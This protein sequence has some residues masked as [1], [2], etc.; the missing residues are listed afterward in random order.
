[1]VEL[2]VECTDV[3]RGVRLGTPEATQLDTH[4]AVTPD[5]QRY[6]SRYSVRDTVAPFWISA[7]VTLADRLQIV[8]DLYDGAWKFQEC[9][10]CAV[11]SHTRGVWSGWWHLRGR[12]S[13]TQDSS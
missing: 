9:P 2:H 10:G 8:D 7:D 13:Y 3:Q 5:E 12:H 6:F 1:M 11:W 4:P